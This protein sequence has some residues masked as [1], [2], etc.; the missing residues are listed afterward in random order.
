MCGRC[1]GEPYRGVNALFNSDLQAVMG[2][3]DRAGWVIVS[4]EVI[5]HIGATALSNEKNPLFRGCQKAVDARSD[6]ERVKL[7]E[8]SKKLARPAFG[9][10]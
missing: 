8:L 1:E 5:V 3:E 7:E 9:A 10:P 2:Y 6:Q 4:G